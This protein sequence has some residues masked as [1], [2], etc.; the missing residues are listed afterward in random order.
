MLRFLVFSLRIINGNFF[1]KIKIIF[2]LFE[3]YVKDHKIYNY[4]KNPKKVDL[5]INL[6]FDHLQQNL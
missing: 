2:G 5:K 3:I 1:I 4:D 6:L